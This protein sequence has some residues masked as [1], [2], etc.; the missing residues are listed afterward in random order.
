MIA[1]ALMSNFAAL[2]TAD[3][4]S[5]KKQANALLALLPAS[6]VVISMDGKRFFDTALPQILSGNKETLDEINAHAEDFK[7]NTGID[8]RQFEQIAVGGAIKQNSADDIDIEPVA[9][10]RGN[11]DANSLVALAKFASENNYREEK[12]GAR[13]VYIFSPKKLIEKHRSTVKNPLMQKILNNLLPRFTHEIAITAYDANT[14]AFG[15]L[16]RLKLMFTESKSRVS[17]DL[18]AAVNR[19]PNAVMNFAASFPN[20][21]SGF[22]KLAD[23]DLGNNLN[24]IRRISGSIDAA[25]EN[26]VIAAAAKSVNLAGAQGL[27]TNLVVLRDFGVGLL[28][29]SKNENNK[30]Y[31]RL[32]ENAKITRNGTEVLLDLSILQSDVNLLLGAK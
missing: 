17:A 15:R 12:V 19:N 29:N 27:H 26:F 18:M 16:E 25:G 5:S 32:I 3:S 24:S 7:K 31:A 1:A 10:A 8:P 14:L 13:T 20:G 11:F 21:I 22:V 6:D 28:G 23:D 2:V 30:L 9:L 4:K